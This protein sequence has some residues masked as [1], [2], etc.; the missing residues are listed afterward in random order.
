MG[1]T[2][3][4]IFNN[5]VNQAFNRVSMDDFLHLC[6]K[7]QVY[8]MSQQDICDAIQSACDFFHI[9][10]PRVIHDMTHVRNG[11]TAFLNRDRGSF[12]DDEISFNLDQLIAMNIET[13]TAFSLVM[14]HECAHRVFQNTIFYGI[15]NGAWEQELCA[16]FFM[17]VRAGL[18]NL[19]DIESVAI[20][21]YHTCASPTHPE[22]ALRTLFVRH[23]K[24]AGLELKS[25][26]VPLTVQNLFNKFNEYL[27]QDRAEIIRFQSRIFR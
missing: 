7:Y 20:G 26:G 11:Q 5:P 2:D 22:G 23:G 12:Y 21:L 1:N 14:T 6:N 18:R 27:Y 19:A 16:D 3:W 10:S 25:A 8:H 15:N 17:G 9:P 4:E 13:K 24:Y